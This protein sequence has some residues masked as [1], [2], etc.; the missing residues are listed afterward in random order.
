[1]TGHPSPPDIAIVNATDRAL[2]L[3]DRSL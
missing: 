2:A 1:M 3:R